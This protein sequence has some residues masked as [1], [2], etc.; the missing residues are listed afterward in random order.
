METTS[1]LKQNAVSIVLAA[2]TVTSSFVITQQSTSYN[3]RRIVNLEKYTRDKSEGLKVVEVDVAV[4]KEQQK[5]NA[6]NNAEI[7]NLLQQTTIELKSTR[8]AVER[9]SAKVD[10]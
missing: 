4:L 5:T 6:V 9:L 7:S 3:S 10:G 8:L 2:M 1:W